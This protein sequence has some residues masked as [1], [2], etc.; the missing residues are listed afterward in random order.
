MSSRATFANRHWSRLPVSEQADGW[1][2]VA[3]RATF[4]VSD[5]AIWYVI[6]RDKGKA[7]AQWLNWPYSRVSVDWFINTSATSLGWLSPGAATDSV[8]PIFSWKNWRPFFAHHVTILL[9]SNGCH[10]WTFSTCPTSF[11]QFFVNSATKFFH[12]G[13]TRGGPPPPLLVMPLVMCTLYKQTYQY[14]GFCFH[15]LN[16]CGKT[17]GYRH[18]PISVKTVRD[19]VKSHKR[20]YAWGTRA[21]PAY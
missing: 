2:G 3:K 4:V 20:I 8:T 21:G 17:Y 6:C 19:K 7:R 1:Q 18:T 16:V 5:T 15:S 12:S 14:P 11:V 13:V 10:P 9:I